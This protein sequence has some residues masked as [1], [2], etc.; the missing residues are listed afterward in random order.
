MRHSTCTSRAS[1][2]VAAW[3]S[4][5][6]SALEQC[7]K[8]G[9]G[10]SQDQA[11]SFGLGFDMTGLVQRHMFTLVC[12]RQDTLVSAICFTLVCFRVAHT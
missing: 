12:V 1:A 11:K 3:N 10:Y 7:I 2:V 5:G 4:G 6:G 9:F 8:A